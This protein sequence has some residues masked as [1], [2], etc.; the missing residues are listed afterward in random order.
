M[1]LS[2]VALSA[3]GE[4]DADGFDGLAVERVFVG[5]FDDGDGGCG[6]GDAGDLAGCQVGG[7]FVVVRP[8]T[9]VH[10][11]GH[12]AKVYKVALYGQCLF[13]F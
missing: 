1:T 6:E 2:A 11:G 10:R 7:E 9:L 12:Y 5:I 8:P 13:K 4:G 3:V